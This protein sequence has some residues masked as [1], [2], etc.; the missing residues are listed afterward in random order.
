ML[1]LHTTGGR[2][3]PN[4]RLRHAMV[5][6]R[7]SVEELARH[8]EVDPKTVERWITKERLPHRRHRWAASKL[9]GR[10]EVYLW[11]SVELQRQ[12]PGAE[13]ELITLYPHRG[14]VPQ[15]LW[16]SLIGEAHQHLDVL[17]YAGLFLFDS[18]PD[19][20]RTVSRKAEAGLHAR[21]LFGDPASR[22]VSDRGEEEGLGDGLAARIRTSLRYL[23]RAYEAPGV[24]VRLHDS[25]LYNSLYRFDDDLLVNMHV[26]G[27]PAPHNPVMHL[28][29]VPDGRLFDHYLDSFSQVWQAAKQLTRVRA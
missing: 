9:L 23:G 4:E 8:V 12:R 2:V 16:A 28:R 20:G 15:Q 27:S 19:L 14:A 7:L 10:D 13:T 21:I 29:R 11:P 6:A 22:V 24:E 25:I 3:V 5:A 1:G 18:N 17:V 26:Y